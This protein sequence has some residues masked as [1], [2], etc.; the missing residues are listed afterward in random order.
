M[1]V[2]VGCGQ[3]TW[4][5]DAAER[6]MQEIA[7]AG[8]DGAPAGP[9]E[10][11][12]TQE[13]LAEFEQ[14]GLEPAPGYLGAD[15]WNPEQEEEILARARAHAEFA[16]Q[17]G[18]GELYVAAG[19]F[20]TYT[21]A[22]GMS[23]AQVAG[24]VAPEDSMTD[25][26]YEQ[27][28]KVLNRVGLITMAQGVHSCFHNHVGSVIETRDEIDRLYDM[29][30]KNAVFMGPDTGHL[31]W[32]GVDPVQ[33]FEDYR[34]VIY[35]AHIKDIDPNVLEKGVAEEWDYATF[36]D[37]GIFTELGQGMVDF[38]A[39]FE[40]LEQISYSGWLI[41]ET[42]VTQ[43]ESALLSAQISREYLNELGI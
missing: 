43:Q 2:K 24:H 29:V 20:Q 4:T 22:R 18:L 9:K 26:E 40:I 30:D 3:L 23:R 27:F 39:I 15:F 34:D 17:A 42:D 21:T 13:V 36:S 11:K 32:G 19:G 37:K 35:T 38:P 7:K 6:A 28:V 33:F 16:S 25:E 8:Y 1:N 14:V 10:G 12:S 41:V 31:I 5:G